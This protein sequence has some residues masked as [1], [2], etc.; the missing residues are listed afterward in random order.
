MVACAQWPLEH[1]SRGGDSQSV[2]SGEQGDLQEM[3]ILRPHPSLEDAATRRVGAL[4][5]SGSPSC[6]GATET[7]PHKIS[8]LARSGFLWTVCK[9]HCWSE[10]GFIPRKWPGDREECTSSSAGRGRLCGTTETC[11]LQAEA[12]EGAWSALTSENQKVAVHS[13]MCG[14]R[15]EG[16]EMWLYV[17]FSVKNSEH[18]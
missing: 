15:A 11:S 6:L 14:R 13:D 17:A 18:P 2:V 12:G 1:A 16:K 3:H 5:G 10:T 8:G 9:N 4:H 7:G